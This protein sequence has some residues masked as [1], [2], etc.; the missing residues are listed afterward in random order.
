MNFQLTLYFNGG[1]SYSKFQASV[2]HSAVVVTLAWMVGWDGACQV[3]LIGVEIGRWDGCTP[4]VG[5]SFWWWW[6]HTALECHS[7]ANREWPN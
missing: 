6:I 4:G 1:H 5:H 7:G 3:G 2:G